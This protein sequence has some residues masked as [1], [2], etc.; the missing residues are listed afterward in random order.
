MQP[1]FIIASALVSALFASTVNAEGFQLINSSKEDL[2]K[3][4]YTNYYFLDVNGNKIEDGV[5]VLYEN[6]R[7]IDK[8]KKFKAYKK[9][10]LKANNKKKL[11]A[12]N[13]K[14][15]ALKR[16]RRGKKQKRG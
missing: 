14:R 10:K 8:K 3:F 13:K 9:K 11:R 1:K 6:K 5:N 12:D 15:R 2:S 16:E 4:S 7:K